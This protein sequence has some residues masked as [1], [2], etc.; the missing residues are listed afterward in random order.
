M[1]ASQLLEL[2]QA[3]LAE[4]ER[5][6]RR[7]PYLDAVE[8]GRAGPESLRRFACEQYWIIAA[9]RRSFAHLAARFP[10]PPAG[11]LF[12]SLAAGEGEA[13]RRLVALAASLGLGGDDLARYRPLPGCHAYT[14]YVAWL[15]LN[16][17]RADVAL[18]FLANLAAWGDNCRRMAEAL[19]PRY[20]VSFLDFFAT[21]SPDFAQRALAVVEQGLT[22]GDCP[23]RARACAA[24]LQAY[25]LGFWDALAHEL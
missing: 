22:A 23:E 6:I 7:H 1:R 3:E 15:A 19:A 25:E 11:D 5:S 21:P 4:T 2:L 10:E 12:L 18:A 8:Q 14:A 9:D 24:L 17:S 16:G 20:D 13:L